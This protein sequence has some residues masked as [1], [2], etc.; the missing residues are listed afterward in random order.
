[1]ASE[2]L[3]SFE[4]LRNGHPFGVTVSLES[5]PFA[6]SFDIILDVVADDTATKLTIAVDSTNGT[7][8]ISGMNMLTST[9]TCLA[10]CA[11]GSILKPLITCFNRDLGKYKSCLKSKG[12]DLLSDA[13]TCALGC[14]ASAVSGSP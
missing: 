2:E 9:A 12:V 5:D 13:V 10:A 7:F 6:Q 4:T 1:M 14:A 3:A 8:N 11:V